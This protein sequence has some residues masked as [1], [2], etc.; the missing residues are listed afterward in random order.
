MANSRIIP[1]SKSKTWETKT[2]LYDIDL[3]S[4]QIW[5]KV[6][7]LV[8]D[9]D[10][11]IRTPVTPLYSARFV[12][13]DNKKVSTRNGLDLRSLNVC[14]EQVDDPTKETNLTVYVPYSPSKPQWKA[15]IKETIEQANALNVTYKGETKAKD[16]GND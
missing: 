8:K 13:V 1:V 4:K 7:L 9:D 12:D 16:Y 15:Q 3:L 5:V 6:R 14:Y 10:R 11:T 2:L